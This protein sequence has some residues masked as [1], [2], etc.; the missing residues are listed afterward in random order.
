MS[1]VTVRAEQQKRLEKKLKKVL[2]NTKNW[3]IIDKDFSWRGVRV[4]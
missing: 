2:T 4:V 1:R 3:Y